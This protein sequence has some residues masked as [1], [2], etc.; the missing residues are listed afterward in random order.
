MVA[1]IPLLRIDSNPAYRVHVRWGVLPGLPLLLLSL[2][3]SASATPRSQSQS[4]PVQDRGTGQGSIGR[5]GCDLTGTWKSKTNDIGDSTWILTPAGRNRYDAQEQSINAAF[6]TAVLEGSQ[7]RIDWSSKIG[8]AGFLEYR[9]GPGCDSGEGRGVGTKLLVGTRPSRFVR[10]SRETSGGINRTPAAAAVPGAQSITVTTAPVIT[11]AT[12]P[13]PPAV[14]GATFPPPPSTAALVPAAPI[15]PTGEPCN[16]P[17]SCGFCLGRGIRGKWNELGGE[18]GSLSCPIMTE[19][20]AARSPLGTTGGF[21]EFSGQEGGYIFWHFNGSYA[22]QAFAVERCFFTMYKS[23]GNSASWLGFPI[24]GVYAVSSGLRQDFE[25]GRIVRNAGT[26][27][28]LAIPGRGT[29][30]PPH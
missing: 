1:V 22:G 5:G 14:P 23:L 25:G 16:G 30:E 6:G 10:V 3:G 29:V 28:C 11:I 27:A 20:E 18:K 4:G 8:Y 9:M 12:L 13:P 19:S 2:L 7:L 21:A 15:G 17:S 24:S 26:G